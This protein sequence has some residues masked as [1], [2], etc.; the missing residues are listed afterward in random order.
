MKLKPIFTF[1]GAYNILLGLAFVFIPSQAMSGAGISP[2][3]DVIAT[4]QIWGA[5]LVGIGWIAFKLKDAE[6]N[7]A[8]VSV[9][10][11]FVVVAGLPVLVTILHLTQGF[12]GPA[13][14]VNLIINGLVAIL[15][16]MKAK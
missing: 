5:A 7:D 11:G 16:F 6:G 8:L 1:Y 12:S 14:Y 13:I 4:H 15:V 10:K 3:T 2:T 9:A